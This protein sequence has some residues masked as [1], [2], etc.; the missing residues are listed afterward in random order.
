[1]KEFLRKETL[2]LYHMG[3]FARTPLGVIR[4]HSV[5][6]APTNSKF[7]DFSQLH[8]YFHLVKSFVTFFCIFYKKN[9]VKFFFFKPKKQRFLTKI[10]KIIFFSQILAFIVSN[11]NCIQY[12]LRN[13]L[14][15]TTCLYVKNWRCWNLFHNCLIFEF[16]QTRG[17][18]WK[19]YAT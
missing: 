3:G 4:S 13:F 12:A 19:G 10:V 9:T 14:R 16:P 11:Q 8:L 18:F 17:C 6:D 5:V 2:T 7:L 15:C 1:M